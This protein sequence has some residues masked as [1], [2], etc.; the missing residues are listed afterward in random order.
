MPLNIPLTLH[1]CVYVPD[2]RPHDVCNFAKCC[3]DALQRI[4]Y[5]NDGRLYATYWE[6]SGVDVDAPRAEITI[7]LAPLGDR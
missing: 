1:A 2:E 5:T 4:V 7:R 3:H 6:R